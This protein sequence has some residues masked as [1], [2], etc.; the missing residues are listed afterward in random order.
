M[1]LWLRAA[2]PREFVEPEGCGLEQ[3][4]PVE[5]IAAFETSFQRL[6]AKG[7]CF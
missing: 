3:S 1:A 4:P 7:H 2:I 5:S 6:R